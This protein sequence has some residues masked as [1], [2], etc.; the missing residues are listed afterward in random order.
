LHRARKGNLAS[1]FFAAVSPDNHASR[2][3]LEKN[4]FSK[5]G[6]DKDWLPYIIDKDGKAEMTLPAKAMHIYTLKL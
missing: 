3:V 1:E 2:R 6:V 4:G 5:T